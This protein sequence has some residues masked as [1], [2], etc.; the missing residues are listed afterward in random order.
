LYSPALQGAPGS[1]PEPGSEVEGFVV[2]VGFFV[3]V[4]A[5]VVDVVGLGFGFGVVGGRQPVV[6]ELVPSVHV[7]QVVDGVVGRYS[8]SPTKKIYDFVRSSVRDPQ[9]LRNLQACPRI[10]RS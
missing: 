8:P 10:F 4:G 6:D 2:V 7:G 9:W 5:L 1:G 3:V